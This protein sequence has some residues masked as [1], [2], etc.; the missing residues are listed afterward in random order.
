MKKLI[1]ALSSLCLA[2]TS[3]LGAFPAIT[4]DNAI[5]AK[6][7]E[8]LVYNLIPN[9]KNY[10][11]A[12]TTGKDNNAYKAAPGEE[13][14]IDWTIKGDPGTAGIQM[15]FD[16][17]QVEY[18]GKKRGNAYRIV[19]TF[20]DYENTSELKKGECIYAWAQSEESQAEDNKVIYS[21][22]IKTPQTNGTYTVGL[23]TLDDNKVIPI[24]Q[25]KTIPFTF[26]G[27]DITVEG[28]SDAPAIPAGTIVYDLVPSGKSYT[29]ASG[30]GKNN[31]YNANAGEE[32]TID[33]T[34]KNDQGT[35]GMEMHFDFTQVEYVSGKRGSAYR[36]VPTYSD[37][38]ST[39]KLQKGECVYTWAQSEENKA[40][41]GSTIYSFN[42]VVPSAKGTYKVGLSNKEESIVLPVDQTK[43]HKFEFHGL[44]IVVANGQ[45]V[46]QAPPD[47]STIIYNLIPSGGKE[48]KSA[49]ENGL[50]N[51][52]YKA[53]AGE[54]LTI[55]WTIKND[56]GTAGLQ[57]N[58]DFTQVEYISGKRGNAYRI[59]PTYSDY[60][61]TTNL[62]QGECI[63]TWAQSEENKAADDS[64]I[65]ADCGYR[66]QGCSD[67]PDQG[68]QDRV[69]RPRY[70]RRRQPESDHHGR[71]V[72]P[73]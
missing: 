20:S 48:Y 3:L 16:F 11:S 64:V 68:T 6:A 42:V 17:T 59:V 22:N 29:P 28:G 8:T 36:I 1:S 13:L 47:A 30:A 5:E 9:G 66:E 62:K 44:D 39:S 7:A 52:V 43:P 53:T 61:S 24:D 18:V 25:T 33:W 23:G 67:R 27:L 2:A 51:N 12:E 73:R 63:Y 57:M 19:P 72:Q 60:K 55:D 69:L 46:T 56:Q 35:A 49:Q 37:S 54:E 71:A 31:V 50:Q 58:F 34:I 38:S 65:S 45:T 15:N 32:L 26:H 10:E 14:T 21:F 41:D 4:A 40:S 70:R